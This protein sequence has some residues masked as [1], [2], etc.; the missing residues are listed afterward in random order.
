MRKKKLLSVVS[1]LL[2][3]MLAIFASNCS[4]EASESTETDLDKSKDLLREY[5]SSF[6]KSGIPTPSAVEA[7][8]GRAQ[9]ENTI[10][11][12]HTAAT[13]ANTYA[14]VVDVL[15]DHYAGLYKSS[16]STYGGNMSYLSTAVDYERKRNT[17]LAM[18][19]DAFLKIA[20]LHL[21]KG[22][23]AEALS[24]AVTAVELSGMAPNVK[25]V[26]LIREIIEYQE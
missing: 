26:A 16:E 24:F 18:R 6:E 13:L 4:R 10:D 7:A 19:N 11:A 14:N 5:L 22:E 25:G 20:R 21:E 23:T 17:Y 12:W 3:G 15:C 8:L 9:A 2:A 1:L